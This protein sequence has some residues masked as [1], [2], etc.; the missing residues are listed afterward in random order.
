M[1]LARN[2]A[3]LPKLDAISALA[4]HRVAVAGQSLAGRL[5]IGFGGVT[6]SMQRA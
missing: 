1:A 6:S 5:L 2:L 4:G 3:V